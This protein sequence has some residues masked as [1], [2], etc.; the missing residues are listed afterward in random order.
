MQ[1]TT[2]TVGDTEKWVRDQNRAI[3]TGNN[4]HKILTEIQELR[5]QL[6]K[7]RP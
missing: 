7:P 1:R 2:K 3:E 5:E 6:A 4:V